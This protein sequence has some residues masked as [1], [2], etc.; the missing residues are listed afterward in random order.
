MTAICNWSR[1]D[2]EHFG[3]KDDYLAV[4]LQKS[5]WNITWVLKSFV[6][7]LQEIVNEI[8]KVTKT[9]GIKHIQIVWIVG[10]YVAI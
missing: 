1:P 8:K 7:S 5:L 10:I 9:S 3:Q 4:K 6:F 2:R